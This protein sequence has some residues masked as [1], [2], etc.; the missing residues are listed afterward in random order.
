MIA[1]RRK[2]SCLATDPDGFQPKWQIV[3]VIK[4]ISPF[5]ETRQ[6]RHFSVSHNAGSLYDR[7]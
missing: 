6:S 5:V 1:A 2:P 4:L 7:A 3:R